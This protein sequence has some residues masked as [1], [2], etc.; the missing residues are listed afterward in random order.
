[1]LGRDIT[2]LTLFI[3]EILSNCK[4]SEGYTCASPRRLIHLTEH[5]SDL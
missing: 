5:K 3:T 1:M 2:I 4:T